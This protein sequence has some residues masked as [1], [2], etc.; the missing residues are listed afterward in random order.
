MP[1]EGGPEDDGPPAVVPAT[2]GN[3]TR[4]SLLDAGAALVQERHTGEVLPGVREVCQKAGRSTAVFY[5]HFDNLAGFHD[6]LLD[7]LLSTDVAFE[8][9]A[10]TMDLLRDVTEKIRTGPPDDIPRLIAS[11]AAANMDGQLAIGIPAFR[12]RLL[13]LATADDRARRHALAAMRRLYEHVTQVQVVGYEALLA[14]WGR[15]PRP[16]YNLRTIAITITAVADGLVARRLFEPDLDVTTL[17]EDAVRSLI[18]T[19]SRRTGT[20]DDLDEALRRSYDPQRPDGS[21]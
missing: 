12:A 17:F 16:P 1:E 6:A 4:A 14:A 21:D 8:V 15:E 7:Q 10:R 3:P 19:L 5:G 11:V 18:P 9:M 20:P 13:F 2:T